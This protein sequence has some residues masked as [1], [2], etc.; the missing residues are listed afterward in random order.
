L[1]Q[2]FEFYFIV[3]FIQKIVMIFSNLLIFNMHY[4]YRICKCFVSYLIR[5]LSQI[6]YIILEI[7][8]EDQYIN[9]S[10]HQYSNL[11][12]NFIMVSKILIK[13]LIAYRLKG[14]HLYIKQFQ[15]SFKI[16]LLLLNLKIII[17]FV[18]KVHYLLAINTTVL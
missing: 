11:Y 4:L 16:Y 14:F 10:N 6:N 3:N 5:I 1:V 15:I 9:F 18:P 17:K 12:L 13:I 8:F 2:S 7:K